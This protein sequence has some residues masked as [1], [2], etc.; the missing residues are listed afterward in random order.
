ICRTFPRPARGLPLLRRKSSRTN[1]PF[2]WARCAASVAW[3]GAA[4]TSSGFSSYRGH[5]YILPGGKPMRY[6]VKWRV[7]DEGPLAPELL[8]NEDAAKERARRL[9]QCHGENL[10]IDVWNEDETWQIVTGA[11]VAAWCGAGAGHEST[12]DDVSWQAD[13][14]CELVPST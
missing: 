5:S 1:S 13:C 8:E 3:S 6:K 2:N 4:T 11:G 12:S 10:I 14:D 9:I 7:G